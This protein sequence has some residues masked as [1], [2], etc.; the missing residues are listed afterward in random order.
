[1]VRDAEELKPAEGRP[2]R[3]AVSD[4]DK[5]ERRTNILAAAKEVF[6]DKGY[7]ATTIADIARAAG[8]SYGSIYLYYDSKE[9]LF[10]E[11]MTAEA[12]ALQDHIDSAI[13]GAPHGLGDD[14]AF[15]SAVR[16]TFEFYEADAALVKLLF[17]DAYSLGERFEQH[18]VE[19]QER[20]LKEIEGVIVVAQRRG[21]I[22]DGPPRLIA[23]TIAGLVGQIAHRRLIDDDGLAP[24]VVADFVVSLVL[25]GLI[26]RPD[27]GAGA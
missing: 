26:P 14:T 2:L 20:F 21:A 17:R 5:A 19:I 16:A 18:L 22:I 7:H 4:E 23:S 24:G 6:A 8:L 10:H 1:M 9:T 27:A 25:N 13:A 15:R 12:A 11:L 3:R